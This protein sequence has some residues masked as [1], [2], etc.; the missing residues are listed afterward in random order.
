MDFIKKSWHVVT[1][2]ATAAFGY[3]SQPSVL[4]VL[5]AKASAFV[6][7]AGAVLAVLGLGHNTHKAANKP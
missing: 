4:D 6:T 5:P 1:G 7:A 3:L 2:V